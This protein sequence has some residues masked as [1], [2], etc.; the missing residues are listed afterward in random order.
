[1]SVHH[2]T[3]IQGKTLPTWPSITVV[4]TVEKTFLFANGSHRP[5]HQHLSSRVFGMPSFL[6]IDPKNEFLQVSIYIYIYICKYIYIYTRW[7]ILIYILGA[8]QRRTICVSSS[9][10]CRGSKGV[11]GLLLAA[12]QVVFP[13]QGVQGR[14]ASKGRSCHFQNKIW[15]GKEFNSVTSLVVFWRCFQVWLRIWWYDI[16]AMSC[17]VMSA[18]W[19]SMVHQESQSAK[20]M[21][22]KKTSV[23]IV[24]KVAFGGNLEKLSTQDCACI[25]IDIHIYI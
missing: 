13:P 12:S 17:H 6:E 19:R 9:S 10:S 15:G 18:L 24:V 11:A 3:R 8:S 25:Y 16:H 7:Y 22:E 21:R 4:S 14:G 20:D 2:V 1:M 5:T 23:L